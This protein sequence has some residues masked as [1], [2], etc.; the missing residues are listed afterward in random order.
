MSLDKNAL[1]QPKGCAILESP[2]KSMNWRLYL[3]IVEESEAEVLV[4]LQ[5]FFLGAP[6]C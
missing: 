2:Y 5:I 4:H 1:D 6:N 3:W